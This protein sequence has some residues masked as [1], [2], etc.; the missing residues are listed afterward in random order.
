MHSPLP[1]YVG[2]YLGGNFFWKNR[3]LA[4][5]RAIV[6][7]GELKDADEVGDEGWYRV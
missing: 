4:K 6:R 2:E 3:D 1:E 5:S 7:H